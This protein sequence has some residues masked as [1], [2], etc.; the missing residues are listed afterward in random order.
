M[1]WRKNI[2]RSVA[3][4]SLLVTGAVATPLE[5]KAMASER[6][7][8]RDRALELFKRAIAVA[9]NIE[10]EREQAVVLAD[11]AASLANAGF[12]ERSRD[13]FANALGTGRQDKEAMRGVVLAIAATGNLNW[14]L[15]ES[16]L[17]ALNELER[18]SLLA[19]IGEVAIALGDRERAEEILLGALQRA[20]GV[21]DESFA[22]WSNGSCS[23]EKFAVLA[24][25]AESLARLGRDERAIATANSVRG[26]YA[27]SHPYA[28]PVEDYQAEAFLGIVANAEDTN[29]L[30]AVLAELTFPAKSYK[31][32]TVRVSETTF[33][34]DN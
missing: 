6:Q 5:E 12:E 26:C 16:A 8:R 20:K 7:D 17:L 4:A 30:Q 31:S 18:A 25:I 9:E 11:I 10:S 28:G 1:L 27:A 33:I 24:R 13:T 34:L 21:A 2:V 23:N 15:E 19:E 14:A 22:Y 29:A 32:L 3:I